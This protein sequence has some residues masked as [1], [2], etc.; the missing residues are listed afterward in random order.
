MADQC[1]AAALDESGDGVYCEQ[2]AGHTGP[3]Y[4]GELGIWWLDVDDWL[5]G[6]ERAGQ[7]GEP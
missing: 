6:S 4:D 2:D 3:H 7:R 1:A 5:S